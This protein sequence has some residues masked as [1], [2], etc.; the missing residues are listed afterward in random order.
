MIKSK[1]KISGYF[2][3]MKLRISGMVLVSATIG[4]FLGGKGISSLTHLLVLLLGIFL[5]CGGSATLNNY[6][7]R[8]VDRQ[9]LR[10][11][12]RPI[13]SGLIEPSQALLFGIVL[14]LLGVFIL[15]WKINLLTSFLSLL[16]A[17][18]YVLV[19]TPLKKVSWLHTTIGAVPGALP[20]LGGWAAATGDIGLG[21][22][23]LFCI[24]FVWQHPHF[25]SIAWLLRD[26]YTKVGFKVLPVVHP[27]GKSTFASIIF[28]SLLLIPISLLPTIIGLSGEVYLWGALLLGLG[29]LAQSVSL[30]STKSHKDAKNLLKASVIYLPVLLTLIVL[31]AAF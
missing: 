27:D 25:Y 2:E 23:I 17:F 16:S 19:Y 24:L 18:L 20:P 14:I 3:L 11:R 4:Y 21:G 28:F 31:D 30:L 13:P 26:D 15:W 12:N 7:E 22:W 10:T 5:V 29:M 6:L 9:M 1:A 8:D